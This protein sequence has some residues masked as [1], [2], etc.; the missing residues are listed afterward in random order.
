MKTLVRLIGL[1]L[2][3]VGL[4][5]A[6]A[7][8]GLLAFVRSVITPTGLVVIAVIRIGVG[9]VFLRAAPHS[10]TPLILRIL[11]VVAILGGIATP[12]VGVERT[13]AVLDWWASQ[14]PPLMRAWAVM[15]ALLGGFFVYTVS[16]NRRPA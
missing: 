16:A 12:L 9:L 15:V 1:V 7:P 8:E 3:G 10:R 13:L 4:F 11:G 5:Y 6:V 2:I 14:G